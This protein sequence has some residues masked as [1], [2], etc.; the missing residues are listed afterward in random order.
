MPAIPALRKVSDNVFPHVAAAIDPPEV[1]VYANVFFGRANGFALR[2]A[3]G[4]KAAAAPQMAL[5]K[6]EVRVAKVKRFG[7]NMTGQPYW[8]P[9]QVLRNL[10]SLNPG[11]EGW[12][13]RSVVDVAAS[14]AGWFSTSPPASGWPEN[15]WDGASFEVIHGAALGKTGTIAHFKAGKDRRPGRFTLSTRDLIL[16]P[17]DHLIL[18]MSRDGDGHRGW[19]VEAENGGRITT[20]TGEA[21]PDSPGRQSLRLRSPGPP[22]KAVVRAM[23]DTLKA[24]DRPFLGLRGNYRLSFSARS[25]SGPAELGVTFQ[26]L[27]EPL[28]PWLERKTEVGETWQRFHLPFTIARDSRSGSL[29]LS[30]EV[31]TGDVL[32]DDVS[33]VRLPRAEEPPNPTAFRNEVVAALHDLRPGILRYHIGHM[34]DTLDN[35][36]AEPFGRR[37]HGYSYWSPEPDPISYPLHHFLALCGEIEAE[38]WIILPITFSEDEI[39]RL[40]AYLGGADDTAMGS[41]RRRQGFRQ[42]WIETFPKI[43]LELGNEAWNPTFRG[44]TF[45]DPAAYGQRGLRLFT[46]ARQ[47]PHYRADRYQLILGGQPITGERNR[48]IQAQS[49]AHDAFT[50]APYLAFDEDEPDSARE[51]FA[52]LFEEVRTQTR[53]GMM[54]A[55][56][57]MLHG[58]GHPVPLCVYE[59]N[60]HTTEGEITQAWLDRL[61]PSAG[62]GI[63]MA[64][65][66]LNLLAELSIRDQCFYNLGQYSFRRADQKSVLLWGAVRNFSEPRLDRP[67]F[68]ALQL[69]NMA[70]Q[71]DMLVTRHRGRL[72]EWPG[73][74]WEKGAFE[75][76]RDL[77][78]YAFRGENGGALVVFNLNLDEPIPIRLNFP[79]G[80]VFPATYY[81]LSY[82]DL[83]DDNEVDETVR[84][85]DFE[86]PEFGHGYQTPLGPASINVWVW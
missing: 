3:A 38:P 61:T 45:E 62:A 75:N 73:V 66:M 11:F 32:L 71:G 40:L 21:R 6:N 29:E 50:L 53:D 2:G 24:G 43:H 81:Q 85:A 7:I 70:L 78:S 44:G 5:Q 9:E 69:C 14:G 63:G 30:F 15:F 58:S 26:R 17:G 76:G 33:L 42:P 52:E 56:H 57:D 31:E 10:V 12:Q 49:A 23:A 20:E 19:W 59:T 86:V 35:L 16:A 51:F 80:A 34:G 36:L 82:L 41:L 77:A 84:I 25:Y 28:R 46:R 27:V 22:G 4:P 72:P 39:T 37:M 1:V 47:S 79:E 60:L 55:N 74:V 8:G 67:T 54:R 48:T 65:H 68:L 18:S 83:T 64:F 13:F